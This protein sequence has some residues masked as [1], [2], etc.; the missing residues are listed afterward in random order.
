MADLMAEGT[1]AGWY[2]H[3]TMAGTQRYWDGAK[4]TDNVAPLTPQG[5]MV[6]VRRRPKAAADVYQH[7]GAPLALVLGVLSLV[8]LGF[9]TGIPAVLV[10][11]RAT[12]EIEAS[13][14]RLDGRGVATAGFVTGLI[15]T[16]L[17]TL[18]VAFVVFA[19]V[20]GAATNDVIDNTYDNTCAP[21]YCP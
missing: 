12:R 2:P 1:P 6:D 20:I 19:F 11:R 4:W 8:G 10:A 9:L 14:G 7:P 18:V 16:V 5:P 21:P 15:G 17:T 13:D 3:P